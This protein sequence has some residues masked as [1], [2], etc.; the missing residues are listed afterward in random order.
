MIISLFNQSRIEYYFVSIFK[1][2][3]PNNLF[4]YSTLIF[5]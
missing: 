4:F 3:V 2:T 5:K 1:K